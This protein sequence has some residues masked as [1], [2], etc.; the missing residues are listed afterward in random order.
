[1]KDIAVIS[2]SSLD[3]SQP[4]LPR[5]YIMATASCRSRITCLRGWLTLESTSSRLSVRCF[6]Y[7]HHHQHLNL[8]GFPNSSAFSS[9]SSSFSPLSS[10]VFQ[11]HLFTS[12]FAYFSK[13][14]PPPNDDLSGAAKPA[15]S[16]AETIPET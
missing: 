15:K 16:S 4:G 8:S 3:S 2:S 10:A 5:R 12:S 7:H 14:A 13:S 6:H 9:S 11:R 1:F